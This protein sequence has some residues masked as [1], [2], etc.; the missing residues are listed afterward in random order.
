MFTGIVEEKGKIRRMQPSGDAIVMA[1]AGKKVLD[2]IHTGDSISVNGV[3]L[4]VTSFSDDSFTVDLMPET[5][6]N[7]SLRGLAAGSEV[8]L[9]RAMAANGRFGGHFVSGHVDG[10]GTIRAK[11]PEYN[12]VY[13][14]IEIDPRLR[15]YMMMKGSVAVDGT[16]LTIFGLSDNTFTISIIPH[17]LEETVIGSKGPG[18]VVNI[19]CDML[20]KYMEELLVRR[21]EAEEAP[22][23]KLSEEFLNEHGFKS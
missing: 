10:L 11:R 3:C 19:E 9:E 4:T 16:S 13:F 20:S 14:D 6:R 5:V 12:A 1:I 17:T 21:F 15:K 8:N 23:E 7:T 18:D 2:D 22:S